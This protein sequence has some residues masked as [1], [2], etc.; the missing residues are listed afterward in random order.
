Q[1][2]TNA[3]NTTEKRAAPREA[4]H[5]DA[6]VNRKHTAVSLTMFGQTGTRLVRVSMP[7]SQPASTKQPTTNA[8]N[9]AKRAKFRLE[10]ALCDGPMRG[11]LRQMPAT[12]QFS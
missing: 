7:S 2:A 11:T 6:P 3:A 8:T 9:A 4:S 12:P 5:S 1:A 10:S